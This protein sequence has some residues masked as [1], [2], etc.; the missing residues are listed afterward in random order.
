MQFQL[1]KKIDGTSKGTGG[2]DMGVL[3]DKILN[4]KY[5]Y[6][7]FGKIES[8]GRIEEYIR[9]NNGSNPFYIGSELIYYFSQ[10]YAIRKD[11]NHEKQ[12]NML[13][14]R[15]RDMGLMQKFMVDS[16]DSRLFLSRSPENNN[17]KLG[18]KVIVGPLVFWIIGIFISIITFFLELKFPK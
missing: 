6:G 15:L 4:K 17:V 14:S 16:L 8:Y 2:F 11:Y 1:L 9:L 12:V 5:I 3:Q 7:P 13:V 18:L 10:G